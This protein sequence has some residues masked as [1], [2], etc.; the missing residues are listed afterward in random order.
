MGPYLVLPRHLDYYAMNFVPILAFSIVPVLY[1]GVIMLLEK[2]ISVRAHSAI[3]LALAISS[4]FLF[5]TLDKNS[6]ESV[7]NWMSY[8]RNRSAI[9]FEEVERA[10]DLG[11]KDCKGVRVTGASNELGPFLHT[12]EKYINKRIGGSLSWFIVASPGTKQDN[13][14]K[15]F[16]IEKVKW[17][18]VSEDD[19]AEKVGCTLEF[20]PKTLRANL[21]FPEPVK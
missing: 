14:K 18:Y 6:R 12:S 1:I 2:R 17:K 11:L 19:E 10:V 3:A 4:V 13:F 9:Q 20:N 16:S 5:S 7:Q 21:L 8:I 15:M